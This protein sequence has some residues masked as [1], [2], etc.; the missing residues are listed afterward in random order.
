MIFQLHR[1]ALNN[2]ESD[3]VAQFAHPAKRR[4]TSSPDFVHAGRALSECSAAD[5]A[6]EIEKKGSRSTGPVI[7]RRRMSLS[8]ELPP[9][10]L[11]HSASMPVTRRP[12]QEEDEMAESAQNG[13]VSHR[14][15]ESD[16]D[17]PRER[18]TSAANFAIGALEM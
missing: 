9:P 4:N 17:R 10:Q 7:P 18:R 14:R 16:V 12:S 15:S 6:A 8:R 13:T 1:K 11:I 3:L 2:I 5:V